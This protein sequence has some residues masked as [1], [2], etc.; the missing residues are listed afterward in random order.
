MAT[1]N[2][3]DSV[4]PATAMSQWPSASMS[5]AT[6]SAVTPDEQAVHG[7]RLGPVALIRMAIS[8]AGMFGMVSRMPAGE[9][10][11]GPRRSNAT[12]CSVSPADPPLLVPTTTATRAPSQCAGSSPASATASRA[13]RTANLTYR[14]IRNAVRPPTASSRSMPETVQA[15]ST[16]QPC[17]SGTVR[18]GDRP[19]RTPSQVVSVVWPTGVIIP[20]PVTA[21]AGRFIGCCSPAP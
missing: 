3:I 14:P 9:V 20:R 7:A 15:K 10:A 21:M 19:A 13:A 12:A 5:R 1:G 18:A 2:T 6:D 8:A 17:S 4:A 11:S 16:A